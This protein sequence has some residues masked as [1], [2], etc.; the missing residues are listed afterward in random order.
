MTEKLKKYTI[1]DWKIGEWIGDA[2]RPGIQ[3]G[4]T[5]SHKLH[6]SF[7]YKVYTDLR[8]A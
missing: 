5:S 3:D 2:L 1:D 4:Y 6:Y 8:E 7:T